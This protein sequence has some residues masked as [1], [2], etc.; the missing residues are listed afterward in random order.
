[1]GTKELVQELRARTGAGIMDCRK[2]LEEAGGDLERALHVLQ[3][4]GIAKAA[5]KSGRVATQG[6]VA[7]YV[8]AGGQV[9]ALLLLRCETDFVA[10]NPVFVDLAKDLAMQVAAMSPAVVK[11]EDVPQGARPEEAALLTQPFIKDQGGRQTV[12]DCIAEKVLELGEN[13][14]VESFTRFAVER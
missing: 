12:G 5:A 7:S 8:H 14:S 3:E 10:K 1:M 6:T 13:I 4:R 11:P 2:A 9:G